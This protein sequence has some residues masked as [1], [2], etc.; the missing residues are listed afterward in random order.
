MI[1]FITEIFDFFLPRFCPACKRRL[2]AVEKYVCPECLNKIQTITPERLQFEFNKKFT[3]KK[4]IS[5]YASLYLFEKDK[6]LQ[7]IIH[8][9]KYNQRFLLGKF[10]GETLGE[11]FQSLFLDWKINLIIPVP[12]HHLKKAERG[13]NQSTFIAKGLR[14]SLGIIVQ[15]NI[16]KRGR[17]T[18]SQ[19]TMNLTER[20]ENVSGAFKISHPEKIAGKNIL[21]V[22]DVITTGSTINECDKVLLDNGAAKVYADSIA[23]AD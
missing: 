12:L 19:T 6:E 10:L 13:Y 11:T 2:A 7:Q 14:K 4:Y 1:T 15:E 9:L 18:R 3:L 21:I 23:I 22:D 20:E 8:A 5:G 17:F 16:L